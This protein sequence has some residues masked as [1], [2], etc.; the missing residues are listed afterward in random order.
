MRYEGAALRPL[1]R[2]TEPLMSAHDIV[3]A[4]TMVA[5]LTQTDANF[6]R[7]GY[8]GVESHYGIGGRWGADGPAGL[9]GAVYQWQ[10]RARQADANGPDGN[11]RVTSVE[12][13]DNAPQS[14]SNIAPW[15]ARQLDALVNL[16]AW[17]CGLEAHADC[18]AGWRC[19]QGVEWRGIRVAIPPTLI[20]DT[21]PGRRGLG[22]HRQGVLHSQGYGVEDYLVAGGERWSESKGK[23]CPGDE[24]VAQFRDVVI[25][26]VQK[27]IIAAA[28]PPE[29]LLED[30]MSTPAERAAFAAEVAHAV[31]E[32]NVPVMGYVDGI[33]QETDDAQTIPQSAQHAAAQAYRA[34]ELAA[35][36]VAEVKALRAEIAALTTPPA[37]G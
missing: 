37:G 31:A 19:R 5:T 17:E 4:H 12:T 6:R 21:K 36:A 23:E 3:C 30:I 8:Q 25:P 35:E 29:S 18:P 10:D 32:L 26:R 27:R 28:A 24:R 33:Y 9:D 11:H 13:A 20:P 22:Y 1:G 7:E 34:R 15:T 16:L 14:A 2:Q